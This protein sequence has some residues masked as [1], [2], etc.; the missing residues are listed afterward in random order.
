M[1]ETEPPELEEL[2][3]A[4]ERHPALLFRLASQMFEQPLRILCTWRPWTSETPD[5]WIRY[6]THDC[7]K[8]VVRPRGSGPEW[9]VEFTEGR[10]GPW[11]GGPFDTLEL[12]KA[13]AD[14]TLH[15]DGWALL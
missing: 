12:G 5:R 11:V 7:V 3:A 2:L 10:L 4:L 15:A 14:T 6:D 1:T 9:E 13:F 8:V